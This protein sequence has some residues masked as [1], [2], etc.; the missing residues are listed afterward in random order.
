M[1]MSILVLL[2]YTGPFCPIGKSPHTYHVSYDFYFY[3]MRLNSRQIAYWLYHHPRT[4][5]I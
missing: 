2:R 4:T 3:S 1:S 5:M